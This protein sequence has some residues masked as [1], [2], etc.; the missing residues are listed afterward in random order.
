MERNPSF[1]ANCNAL[2]AILMEPF[3]ELHN[4]KSTIEKIANFLCSTWATSPS[5]TSDKW[6]SR[7][8]L[9]LRMLDYQN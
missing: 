4:F 6:V 5:L 9:L 2:L 8:G 3:S 1:S 7:I